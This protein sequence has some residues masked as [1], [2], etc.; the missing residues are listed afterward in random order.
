VIMAEYSD[1][2]KSLFA[3]SKNRELQSRGRTEEVSD[4]EYFNDVNEPIPVAKY[5]DRPGYLRIEVNTT[6][7]FGIFGGSGSGKTTAD[8]TIATRCFNRGRIP[9]NFA[10]TDLHTTNLDNHGGVSKKLI[11]KM[12]LYN[13]EEPTEIPQKTVLPKYLW[14]K[15]SEN[16]RPSNVEKFS[17]GFQDIND[18]ELKFLLGQGLDSNQMQAMQTVIDN[19]DVDGSLTFDDL[20]NAA[21]NAEDIHHSTAKKLKRNIKNLES[22]EVISNRYQKDIVKIVK[23]GNSLGIGMR[24]FN[25][26]SPSD[27]YLMEFLAKKCFEKIVDARKSGELD[28]SI[29]SIFPEAHHLMPRGE[30]SLLADYVK[31]VATYHQRRT[32]TPMILDSQNPSQI[33]ENILEEVNS[34]FIGCD[35]SGKS[36]AKSEWSDVLKKMNVVANPQKDN[37]RWMKKIQTLNHRDFLY[38]S[39]DMTDPNDAPVVRF[40][41]PLTSNP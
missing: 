11:E 40:L 36:L 16:R 39:A 2:T 12:G 23:D 19:V 15:L 14:N 26:L 20:K 30:D 10:D 7:V 27:Y 28:Q 8:M 18:S 6:S 9:A 34:V 24:G 22:S 37:R 1:S 4:P 33:P 17:L 32:D 29:F 13:G 41:S 3:R 38:I 35:E 21:E 5:R 31:R 25:G